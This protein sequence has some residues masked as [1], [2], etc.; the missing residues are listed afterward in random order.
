MV[1][2]ALKIKIGHMIECVYVHCHRQVIRY[3]LSV[4]AAGLSNE[5]SPATLRSGVRAVQEKEL[6]RAK[7]LRKLVLAMV[8]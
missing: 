2:S 5:K 8:N 4:E 3:D 1:K 7:T 6:A